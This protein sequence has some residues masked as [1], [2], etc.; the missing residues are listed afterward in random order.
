MPA[1]IQIRRCLPHDAAAVQALLRETWVAAYEP[2]MGVDFARGA[3]NRF[4]R[5][6]LAWT[7][8][9]CLLG[10]GIMLKALVADEPAGVAYAVHEASG[11]ILY[12]LYVRPSLQGRGVGSSLLAAVEAWSPKAKS[13]RLEVLEANTSA[14][15]WYGSKGFVQYG[16]TDHATGSPG[17]AA[18]YMDKSLPGTGG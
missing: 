5:L 7:S 16:R 14:I 8:A 3:A 17:V 2:I 13:I 6:Y 18:I 11:V 1:A 12:M 4:T 15:D 9:S 10:N